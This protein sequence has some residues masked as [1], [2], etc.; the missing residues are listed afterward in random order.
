M[1][2][3]WLQ[4]GGASP[5]GGCSGPGP[6]VLLPVVIYIVRSNGDL[7]MVSSIGKIGKTS[8]KVIADNAHKVIQGLLA[9]LPSETLYWF[10]SKVL[11]LSPDVSTNTVE[12]IKSQ[13]TTGALQRNSDVD[14]PR[15]AT[16]PRMIEAAGGRG[17]IE[18]RLERLEASLRMFE[19]PDTPTRLL[20]Y[21]SE[22]VRSLLQTTNGGLDTQ[23]DHEHN[24]TLV[25]SSMALSILQE[26]PRDR[27]EDETMAIVSSRS[28]GRVD[29]SSVA[30]ELGLRKPTLGSEPSR[31]RALTVIPGLGH[32]LLDWAG[33]RLKQSFRP[34]VAS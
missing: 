29:S 7:S 21:S 17:E 33:E 23:R 16:T 9:R 6:L 13:S 3:P 24:G 14:E 1:P 10:C 27:T 19:T 30:Q 22:D 31:R 8:P 11:N 4:S 28:T 2:P 15:L 26:Q 12:F 5:A 34:A 32:I 25:Q 18:Q 20:D